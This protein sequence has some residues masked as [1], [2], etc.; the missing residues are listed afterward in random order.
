MLEGRGFIESK[1]NLYKAD[2]V[3]IELLEYYANS[4]AHWENV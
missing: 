4:I 1:D 3:A 2:E